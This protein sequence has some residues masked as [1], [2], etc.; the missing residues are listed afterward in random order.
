MTGSGHNM[1]KQWEQI[2]GDEIRDRVIDGAALLVGGPSGDLFEYAAGTA[3]Q[4]VPM[5]CG[6][7][8]DI[9]ST[10]K[11]VATATALLI[12][13]DRGL[14]DF[15]APF[16]KYLADFDAP[17]PYG[18]VTVRDLA[19]HISGFSHEGM[20]TRQYFAEDGREML[21]NM[22]RYPPLFP[23]RRRFEYTC[24][25][26]GLLGQ[27][28]E[29]ITG[30]TLEEFC[31]TEIFEPLGMNDSS[32]GR[33]VVAD[34][35]RLARTCGTA[36]PGEI[37]DF[38]AFRVY[39]DGCCAGNAGMFSTAR[40][41]G[42]FCRALLAGGGGLFSEQA[43]REITVNAMPPG[44]P[45]RSFGWVMRDEFKPEAGSGRMIYHSGWS[46]QTVFID[47][48]RSCYVV[49]LTTRHGDYERAKR[50]RSKITSLL[51]ETYSG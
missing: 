48:G 23:P 35:S 38:V 3:A 12:C 1:N 41:L 13:R 39:R 32:L 2:I 6:T 21:T 24:W 15:D 46:G 44:L 19:L 42:K 9:A 40:D 17:L 43:F 36:A 51:L 4:G 16:T 50:E 10:T 26:Y 25:N 28:V 30:R 27:I 33:P 34:S 45:E 5:N 7:V 29:R 31:R 11:A 8:I 14:V 47:F 18:P 22:L 49:V 20:A 37:S